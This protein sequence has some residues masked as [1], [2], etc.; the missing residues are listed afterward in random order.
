M[1]FINILNLIL[2]KHNY[3]V[4]V[5]V[6]SVSGVSGV[7]SG[8]YKF[9]GLEFQGPTT[10]ASL[11]LIVIHSYFCRLLDGFVHHWFYK[12][13]EW[14]IRLPNYSIEGGEGGRGGGAPTKFILP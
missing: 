2:R 5:T 6:V 7:S 3:S 13:N 10:V 1:I 8:T 12:L 14:T 4:L 9:T 11:N